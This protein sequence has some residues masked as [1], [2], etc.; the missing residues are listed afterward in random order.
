MWSDSHPARAR[1]AS[2]GT[3]R[4]A[5]P[6][7]RGGRRGQRDSGEDSRLDPASETPA[8]PES[9]ARQIVL[10]K[11]S[12]QARTRHELASALAAKRVPDD[13]ATTILDRFTELGLIDDGQF[14][15]DWVES[16]QNRR[17]L[18]RSALRREL[19]TRGV[20]AEHI[21]EA[22]APVGSE[23]ELT[24]A[25]QLVEK[26]LRSMERLEPAVRYRRLA[27]A[28]GRRGFG[29]GVITTVLDELPRAAPVDGP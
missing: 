26:K 14:A 17:S 5:D 6:S 18:S 11:L 25:R 10:R 3:G 16:R 29:S 28:L 27:G 4:A 20:D 22:L 1:R 15:R 24:A 9:V 8:D 21:A 19:Q 23:E 2:P 13:A 12:A 7:R